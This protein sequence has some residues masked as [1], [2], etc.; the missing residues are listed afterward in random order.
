MAD[1]KA[2][3]EVTADDGEGAGDPEQEEPKIEFKPL[4]KLSEVEVVTHE[5]DEEVLFKMR[6]KLFRY[7]KETAQWK[8]RGTGDV[9][10]L[11][12]KQS[13]KIRLLM[14]REKTL[15]VCA[16]H[17]I[18]PEFKLQANVGSDRSWVW[19][20]PSDFA[21]DEAKPEVFAIRFA[22]AD[23]ANKFKAEFEKAQE[24][25]GQLGASSQS[26]EEIQ[27]ELQKLNMKEEETARK[28]EQ[29]EKSDKDAAAPAE[30]ESK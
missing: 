18:L 6:A 22:N 3:A 16:N 20:C 13:S 11:K 27:K 5:E 19:T 7:D 12:H 26:E 10:F 25:M 15:K 4:V 24:Q 17:F 8:E 9:K 29:Q 21:E 28:E 30:P 14:R 2:E 1:P 23:N